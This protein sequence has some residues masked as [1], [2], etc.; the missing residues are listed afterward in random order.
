MRYPVI[1]IIF[2]TTAAV[3]MT[4]KLEQIYII[5]T[6]VVMKIDPWLGTSDVEGNETYHTDLESNWA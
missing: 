6:A 4:D 2:L 1:I 3:T 5:I